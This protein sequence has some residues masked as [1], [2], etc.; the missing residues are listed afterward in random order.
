MPCFHDTEPVLVTQVFVPKEYALRITR[1][2]D[3][4]I[5]RLPLK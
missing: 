3:L 4:K 2:L 5:H 1:S